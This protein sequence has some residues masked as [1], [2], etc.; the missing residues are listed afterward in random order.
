MVW[1][2]YGKDAMLSLTALSMQFDCNNAFTS[3][4][5]SDYILNIFQLDRSDFIMNYMKDTY[6]INKKDCK[7]FVSELKKDGDKYWEAIRAL[8]DFIRNTTA[9]PDN[10][11]M[12]LDLFHNIMLDMLLPELDC[13]F[14]VKID[15]IKDQYP[16]T[17]YIFS[18]IHNARNQETAAHYKDNKGNIRK[19]IT[20]ERLK[21]LID[22]DQLKDAY[23]EVFEALNNV[24]I[25]P[26]SN[27]AA[28]AAIKQGKGN[29]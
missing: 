12:N 9:F 25:A 6:K 20:Q 10:A 14:G 22:K 18:K 29:K 19:P 27:T 23:I 8:N 13:D 5:C 21:V 7:C 3:D 24:L 15:H 1:S 17:Y 11:L 16:C 28:Q 26:L 2:N 4:N